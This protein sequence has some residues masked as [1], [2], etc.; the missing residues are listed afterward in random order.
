MLK[1]LVPGDVAWAPDIFHDDDPTLAKGGARPWLIISNDRYPGQKEGN[2]YVGL[3]LTSSLAKHDSMMALEPTAWENGGGGRPRQIDAE[4]IQ[5]VKHHWCASHLG[6][7][8]G[9]KVR[10][11]RKKVTAWIA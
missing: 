9:A 8:K 5:V 10:E 4:T 3:A 11:A 1:R 6:R 2:Q 7:V